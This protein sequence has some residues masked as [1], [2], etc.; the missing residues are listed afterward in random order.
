MVTLPEATSTNK[1]SIHID[2]RRAVVQQPRFRLRQKITFITLALSIAAILGIFIVGYIIAF[3]L[4]PRELVVRV[5]DVEYHRGDLVELVRINQK[6]AE[7]FG[8]TFDASSSVFE[9]LQMIVENEIILQSAPS[10]GITVSEAEVDAQI[11]SVMRPSSNF[12]S[13]KSDEQIARETRERYSSYLNTIQID[14]STHRDIVRRT[15]AR[16][17]FRQYIGDSVPFVAEQVRVHRLIM[18]ALGEIDIM[19]VKFED[20]TRDAKTPQDLAVAY[21]KVVREFSSDTPATLRRGG[22]LGWIAEGVIPEYERDFF[23]LEPGEI[24]EPVK[25]KENANQA[26]FFMI[27]ERHMAQE[28]SAGVRDELKTRALQEWVNKERKNYEVY[29]VFNSDIYSWIFKQ[30]RLSSTAPTPTPDPFQSMLNPQ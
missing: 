7:F 5:N 4:P 25:N 3:V 21:S 6:T 15:M 12:E 23:Y 11:D 29:A 14:E 8:G 18:P 27:S 16:E 28:L 13:G 1:D 9:S 24:S 17:R 30:L 10:H 2:R 22:D 20:A 26:I 19:K